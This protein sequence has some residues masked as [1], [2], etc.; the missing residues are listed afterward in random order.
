MKKQLVI[1]GILTI[2]VSVE[3]S[4]CN[5][6]SNLF[7]TDE[8]KLVGTWNSDGI[9]FEG[10][11]VLVF[12]SDGTFKGTFKV[13]IL[14]STGIGFSFSKGKWD[15]NKGIL[16]MEIVDIS[17]PLTNYTYQFSEDCRALNIT[18]IDSSE[19]YILRKQ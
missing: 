9:W 16:T 3:L 10:P 19:S 8:E 12:S 14:N 13:G 2:L 11:T 5:Q 4:G 18:E 15:I 6:I 7:L 17:I 1:I